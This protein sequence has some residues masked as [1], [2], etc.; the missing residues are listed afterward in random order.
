[1]YILFLFSF[2]G[3][4]SIKRKA[5]RN[6][7]LSSLPFA[8][9]HQQLSAPRRKLTTSATYIYI[10]LFFLSL[11]IY[12]FFFHFIFHDDSIFRGALYI[13]YIAKPER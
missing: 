1:M 2:Q 7:L 11:D 6:S 10:Y 13:V 5:W 3:H 4:A 12:F 9:Y 8:I